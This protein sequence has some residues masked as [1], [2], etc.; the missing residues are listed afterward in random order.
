MQPQVF[1]LFPAPMMHVPGVIDGALAGEIAARLGAAASVGNDRSDALTHSRLLGPGEDPGVDQVVAAVGP[2]VQAMGELMFGEQLRWLVKEIWV[3][4][5]DQGGHQALHN[6]ANSFVSGVLYLT[7]CDAS[8][9]TV[10]LR[11]IG[12][13]EFAFRNTHERMKPGPFNADKWVAPECAP[14]DLL[15]FP[16]W[17]L[18]EVPANRG[19]RRVTL[20]FNAIPERLDAWGYT[21]S[22]QP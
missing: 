9:R 21:V 1:Q 3:N 12:G 19:G 17:M 6:H 14:G 15:L 10:F 18:H 5:L 8:A 20:A 13:G 2:H 16:S 11:G 7:P 4:V 22:L